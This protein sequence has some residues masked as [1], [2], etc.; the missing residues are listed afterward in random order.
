MSSGKASKFMDAGEIEVK[1]GV[2]ASRK[3]GR[4]EAEALVA[5]ASKVIV[6]K[7]KKVTTFRP[8]RDPTEEVV[9][10]MLGST[11]NLRAPTIRV[12]KTVVVGYN[13]AVYAEVLS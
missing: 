5:R 13:D 12:G 9:A 1:E 7:G 4:A 8:G 2:P 3:L 10:P 6:A 11:G